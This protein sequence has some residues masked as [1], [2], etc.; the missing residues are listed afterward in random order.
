MFIIHSEDTWYITNDIHAEEGDLKSGEKDEVFVPEL[1]WE[2]LDQS[3]IEANAW[4]TDDTLKV[5]HGVD[6]KE[7]MIAL[8]L[9]G[10]LASSLLL[11]GVMVTGLGIW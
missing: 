3:P 11:I 4:K 10:I 1:S 9:H 2:F 6:Q 8:K 5:T 7:M